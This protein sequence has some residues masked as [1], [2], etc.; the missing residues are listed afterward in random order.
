MCNT[1]VKEYG[2]MLFKLGE[3][4]I[5]LFQKQKLGKS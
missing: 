2:K 1:I 5:L 3:K 4:I